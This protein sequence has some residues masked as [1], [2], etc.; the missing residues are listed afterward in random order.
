[1]AQNVTLQHLERSKS[2]IKANSTIGFLDLKNIELDTK[3]II[4]SALSSKVKVKDFFLHNGNQCNAFMYT[5]R[6]NCSRY[7][8]IY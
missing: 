2:Q 4:L 6:S 7:F 3:I 1:M 5:T 8:L